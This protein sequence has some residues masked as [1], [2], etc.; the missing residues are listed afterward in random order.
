MK[1]PELEAIVAR[2]TY[3]P[4]W[5]IRVVDEGTRG[6]NPLVRLVLSLETIDS[7]WL[8]SQIGLRVTFEESL[9]VSTFQDERD[10]VEYVWQ[11]LQFAENH[12]ACEFFRLDGKPVRDPHR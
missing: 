4:G 12:E 2:I 1:F 8:P 9:P 10:F 11:R 5:Q 6:P 7:N 3:R